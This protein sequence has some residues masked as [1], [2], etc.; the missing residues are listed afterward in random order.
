[1]SLLRNMTMFATNKVHTR[2]HKLNGAWES[3]TFFFLLFLCNAFIALSLPLL[4][5]FTYT[6]H[7]NRNYSVDSFFFSSF[8]AVLVTAAV[9]EI[10]FLSIHANN[11]FKLFSILWSLFFFISKHLVFFHQVLYLTPTDFGCRSDHIS[12]II[13]VT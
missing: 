13:F 2:N 7:I 12:L 10:S 6:A 9:F 8:H 11:N 3:V 1:M 4:I 5:P